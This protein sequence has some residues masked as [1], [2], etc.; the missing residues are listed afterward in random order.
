[1]G[2][3]V[4]AYEDKKHEAKWA[5]DEV[6]CRDSVTLPPGDCRTAGR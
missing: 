2:L 1:L 3:T 4:L 5:F 6:L